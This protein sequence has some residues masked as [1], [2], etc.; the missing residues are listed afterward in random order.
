M[1]S[2]CCVLFLCVRMCVVSRSWSWL[3][4]DAFHVAACVSVAVDVSDS[5]GVV[6]VY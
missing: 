1:S 2:S 3:T 5:A 4:L 6:A